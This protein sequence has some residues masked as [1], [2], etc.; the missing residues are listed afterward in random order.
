MTTS[1]LRR[2]LAPLAA[3]ALA[4]SAQAQAQDAVTVETR[5]EA[6]GTATLVHELLVGAPA[7][8]VWAAIST[9]EGWTIWAVPAAWWVEGEPDVLETSYDPADKPGS[10][11]TIRQRFLARI[12]G[13]L[14]AFR[15]IKAPAGFPHWESYRLVTS[16]FELEP[17][18]QR[19]RVR[20][21]S[22][23]YPDSEAGRE[24][25][26]FFTR[27]NAETLEQ[28]AARFAAE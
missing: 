5:I 6:D 24:L 22:T 11:S 26:A 19:T 4:A 16:V 3:V 28:L 23:G 18:G 7:A 9:P 17:A 27:G 20:L 25:V 1:L 14:L 8:Q 10:A 12:P 21:T 2:A 15:T 13:R